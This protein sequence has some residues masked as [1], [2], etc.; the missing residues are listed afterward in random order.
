[1]PRGA[2]ARSPRADEV[3]AM[4]DP[5]A[6]VAIIGLACR[7]PASGDAGTFWGRLERG[8]D[9]IA[10]LSAEQLSAAGSDPGALGPDHVRRWGVAPGVEDFDAGF[11]GLTPRE[12]EATDPQQRLF[13][14]LV[15]DALDDAG[16]GRRSTRPLT[17]LFVAPGLSGYEAMVR[18]TPGLAE[19]VGDML[20]E[21]GNAP[22]HMAGRSAHRFDL[23]GPTMTVQTACS[24]SLVA[25][26]AACAALLGQ[27]CD[28]AIA[29]GV[30]IKLPQ[31]AG[32]RH[33]AGGIASPDGR[34]R[35]FDAS[36]AGTV[37]GNGGGV[38]I[39]RRLDD[40]IRDGDSIRA[41]I[42]GSAVNND[43]SR[44]PG[45]AA[46]SAAGQAEVISAAMAMA[47]VRP[48]SISYVEC[49]G[50]GTPLGDAI[51]L[52]ALARAFAGKRERP[53]AIGSVKSNIGHLR[54]AAGIA[55]LIKTV[56]ALEQGTIPPTLHF[57]ALP[58]EAEVDDR[59]L[60]VAQR[61]IPWPAV[62]ETRR[63]AGISSFGLGGTNA[64]LVLEE[65]PRRPPRPESREEQLLLLSSWSE[66][67]LD[68]AAGRL[69]DALDRADVPLRDL[70][71]TLQQGREHH[72]H[73][74]AVAGDRAGTAAALRAARR[75]APPVQA[76]PKIAFL[77]AGT[78]EGYAGLAAELYATE[79][80][81][82]RHVD[83]GLD[84]AQPYLRRD[85]RGLIGIETGRTPPA[86]G[87]LRALLRAARCAD[88]RKTE[89]LDLVEQHCAD[90][91][92]VHAGA[93][94]WR[95][96]GIEPDALL[97]Y[98]LGEYIAAAIAGL[99]TLDDALGIVAARA[100]LI[101]RHDQ[102]G[103]LAVC[104]S[105]EAVRPHLSRGLAVAAISAPSLSVVAGPSA[106]LDALQEALAADNVAVRRLP[107]RHAI[108][109]AEMNEAARAL[110]AVIAGTPRRPPSIPLVSNVTGALLAPADAVDPRHWGRHLTHPVQ[111]A[112]GIR[113][114]IDGGHNLFV[115]IGPGQTLSSVVN[116]AAAGAPLVTVQT[117]PA[118]RDPRS[119]RAVWLQGLGRAWTCGAE[120]DWVALAAPDRPA[121][122]S[123]P[124]YGW[125]K[126]RYALA[127]VAAE[128]PPAAAAPVTA[129][130]EADEPGAAADLPRFAS[131]TEAAIGAL[132]SEMTGAPDV[133]R[134]D[135][136]FGLGGQSLL[137]LQLLVRLKERFGR[138]LDM[139]ALYRNATVGALAALV[140][141]RGGKA[142]AEPPRRNPARRA[143]AQS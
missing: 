114:L 76:R 20:V 33:Q 41:V 86:G 108:H 128:R 89:P 10:E 129:P 8:E 36:A 82:R 130:G 24:S 91:I 112:G 84:A 78:G 54:E 63:R 39:L 100:T 75:P 64:H 119:D 3:G 81:F 13:L 135:D 139:P 74:L 113:T 1:V 7:F 34:T 62:E 131:E 35:S 93:Q 4:T 133:R 123:A 51:E 79:P 50:S 40:A 15:A 73:R 5:A 42:L 96:A 98:S 31:T 121:R 87:D 77:L 21:I 59:Q 55:G 80:A 132:F 69:A 16:Y 111:L 52:A 17:G 143:R 44:R 70:A 120:P 125:Q 56:L 30:S 37:G 19:A 99:F 58:A 45:Y 106:A 14:E 126:R 85:L 142:A 138:E 118:V 48:D 60:A 29:G 43:G 116:Q 46:P 83:A 2:A 97:G 72:P 57:T 103:M 12:A 27:E 49:H 88:G 134:E 23:Q 110:E 32:Y 11:F 67:G 9:C 95:E 61:P 115:E 109:T 66:Q 141:A 102:G 105:A 47:A 104:M 6:S 25:V 38:V 122:V 71:F 22:E 90:F 117:L 68:A 127:P 65:A 53:L 28:L 107:G 94:L 137:A 101:A 136:F 26:H 92:I 18:A 140:E 124:G